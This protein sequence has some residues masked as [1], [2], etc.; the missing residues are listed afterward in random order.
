MYQVSNLNKSYKIDKNNSNQVLKDITFNISAGEFLVIQ[1][2]S[3][4]GKST[5]L[6]V[7]A[8]LDRNYTGSVKFKNI[9][10]QKINR[11]N[12]LRGEIGFI[13]QNFNLLDKETV[14]TN[15][16]TSLLHLKVENRKDLIQEILTNV[17]LEKFAKSKVMDLSGGQKQ[18]VAIARAIIK[19]PKLIIADEPTGS[20]DREN[21]NE[22]LNILRQINNNGTTIIMVT[23]DPELM[24][25]GSRSIKIEDGR[26]LE[27]KLI[28]DKTTSVTDSHKS[29]YA[30]KKSTSIK[31]LV[32]I[33]LKQ[34]RKRWGKI[35][36]TVAGI[37]IG[38]AAILG[39]NTL[40]RVIQQQLNNAG[41]A[42]VE[43]TNI[44]YIEGPDQS[45][46][47]SIL[48]DYK[49]TSITPTYRIKGIKAYT[50]NPVS[51]EEIEINGIDNDV[52]S[53]VNLADNTVYSASYQANNPAEVQEVQINGKNANL[54]AA[55]LTPEQENI[56]YQKYPPFG[57]NSVYV[58]Q[59][60][61]NNILANMTAE[62][63]QIATA[64]YE[65]QFTNVAEA[66]KF[67][68]QYE[69]DNT[70]VIGRPNSTNILLR[71]A[72]KNLFT[73]VYAIIAFGLLMSIATICIL[74]YIRVR[75][76]RK[77]YSIRKILGSSNRE[78][79][80][81]LLLDNIIQV[82]LGVLI[83]TFVAEGIFAW[84][85]S[86]ERFPTGYVHQTNYVLIFAIFT[87]ISIIIGIVTLLITRKI[88][89]VEP[90]EALKYE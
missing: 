65:V 90:V 26:I 79:S 55:Y 88:N 60:T 46:I 82:G 59:K 9:E 68:A 48:T 1:G 25:V 74:T 30:V 40:N 71:D 57:G 67:Y 76:S 34:Q 77:E 18:R 85:Q 43:N 21:R 11:T 64:Y 58:N 3:G 32:K 70:M 28:L 51:G 66:N 54:S 61:M 15:I 39:I 78:L 50:L 35:L 12:Y 84:M 72:V 24:N 37:I 86:T 16:E 14:Y 73:P 42:S 53:K 63:K 38:V 10:M 56:I 47:E 19:K 17:G 13:F 8:G 6:N 23:H 22:L 83:G 80:R 89:K 29:N 69:K 27:D 49:Y 31:D 36:L 44:V 45:K 81:I 87:I 52:Q 2:E 7:L 20:L 62:E 4:S 41:L 75:D 5:L 33:T